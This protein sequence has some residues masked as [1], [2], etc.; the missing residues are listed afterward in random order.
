M[1]LPTKIPWNSLQMNK[2]IILGIWI[3]PPIMIAKAL[4]KRTKFL[5]IFIFTFDWEKP[6][7]KER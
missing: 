7:K 1:K 2:T 4:K 5:D 6:W 3:T